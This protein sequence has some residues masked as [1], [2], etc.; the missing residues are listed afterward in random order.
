[1]PATGDRGYWDWALMIYAR[2]GAPEACLELQDQFG[3]CTAYLLW[4]AWAAQSGRVLAPAVLDAGADLAARWEA[5]A[6]GPLRAVRR[7]LK[8]SMPGLADPAREALRT[9]VKAL[10][11]KSERLL[12]ET[13][14]ALPSAP[15]TPPA[16]IVALE[17]AARAWPRPAPTSAL[18]RLA[19]TLS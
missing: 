9:E 14:E 11:L 15:G 12:M 1:M 16:V 5:A 19:Q 6:V 17:A 8:P 2:P 7:A 18:E 3:Q 4:A 13:L 10:E